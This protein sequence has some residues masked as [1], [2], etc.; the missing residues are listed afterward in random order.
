MQTPPGEI[1]DWLPVEFERFL[2]GSVHPDVMRPSYTRT[3]RGLTMDVPAG[4]WMFRKGRV[5][6]PFLLCRRNQFAAG[7]PTCLPPT[8]APS[9]DPH[10]REKNKDRTS[11]PSDPGKRPP[12]PR[13]WN[14]LQ[15]R[16]ELSFSFASQR[17]SSQPHQDTAM[18]FRSLEPLVRAL[19][20]R[21]LATSPIAFSSDPNAAASVCRK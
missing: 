10:D 1:L 15:V 19:Q 17:S 5:F 11:V 20:A 13:S 16:L 18:Q 6:R 2:A 8:I 9:I 21:H 14:R 3:V 7:C 12:G 4:R